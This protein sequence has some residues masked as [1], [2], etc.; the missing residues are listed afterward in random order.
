MSEAPGYNPEEEKDEIVHQNL[1]ALNDKLGSYVAQETFGRYGYR[2]EAGQKLPLAL[3]AFYFNRENGVIVSLSREDPGTR[4]SLRANLEVVAPRRDLQDP[5]YESGSPYKL[6]KIVYGPS[7]K[8]VP[9]EEA[10]RNLD[11]TLKAWNETVYG[12]QP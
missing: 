10:K 12:A 5:K 11:E 7:E 9:S 1:S 8:G 4:G 3:P 6:L 2:E